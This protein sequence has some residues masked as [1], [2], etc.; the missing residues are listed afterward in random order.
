MSDT[1]S[2]VARR[3]SPETLSEEASVLLHRGTEGS[4]S[5]VLVSRKDTEKMAQHLTQRASRLCACVCVCV[6]SLSRSPEL[7]VLIYT[8][9]LE[10]VF[11]FMCESV[12]VSCLVFHKLCIFMLQL[13]HKPPIW[14]SVSQNAEEEE[15]R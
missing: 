12:F 5:F 8:C 13:L 10:C 15:G 2:T 3:H 11:F 14:F 4:P 9:P 1:P 7:R 6:E